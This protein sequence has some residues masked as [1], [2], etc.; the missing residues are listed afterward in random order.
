MGQIVAH[1]PEIPDSDFLKQN[2]SLTLNPKENSVVSGAQAS[3]IGLQFAD[4]NY[5]GSSVIGAVL[6]E[7]HDA[8]GTDAVGRPDWIIS[9]RPPAAALTIGTPEQRVKYLYAGVDPR[10]SKFLGLS[11]DSVPTSSSSPNPAAIC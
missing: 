4:Q 1:V 5:A 8:C 9:L 7:T 3:R 10:T 6:V 2:V 11:V